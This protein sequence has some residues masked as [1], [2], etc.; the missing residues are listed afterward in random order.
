MLLAYL[1]IWEEM[2]LSLRKKLPKKFCI[3]LTLPHKQIYEY[4]LSEG[5]RGFD[6]PNWVGDKK[7]T[8]LWAFCDHSKYTP[9]STN[10]DWQQRPC[11]AP[12]HSPGSP[13]APLWQSAFRYSAHLEAQHWLFTEYSAPGCCKS[14][15]KRRNQT[16]TFLT[17]RIVTQFM[18]C[19]VSKG[20]E[21]F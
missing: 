11:C 14:F 18:S 9:S 2:S 20:C 19:T 16:I 13:K 6:Q 3:F 17:S 10:W 12:H 1:Q 21:N 8:W 7:T 15:I 4:V 5:W